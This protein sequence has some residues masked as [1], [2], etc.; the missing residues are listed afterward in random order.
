MKNLYITMFT[1]LIAGLINAQVSFSHDGNSVTV[2]YTPSEGNLP[3]NGSGEY[4]PADG[5]TPNI[6]AWCGE[7]DNSAG[8][9]AGLFGDWPGTQMTDNGNGSFSA[10]V[11]FSNF[12]AAGTTI[13]QMNFIFNGSTGQ[14]TDLGATN[15]GF[16]AFTV[17]NLGV[18]NLNSTQPIVQ[19]VGNQLMINK[20]G[21]YD[22]LVY[23]A[24]GQFVKKLQFSSAGL[25]PLNLN[26]KGIYFVRVKDDNGKVYSLKSIQK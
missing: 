22:V 10:T 21:N 15:Y 6:Y 1:L 19:M 4:S 9:F 18:A 14:T 25:Q 2:T 20:K 3:D 17:E 7:A 23:N 5:E 13:N 12:Y 16:T 24:A 8:T 26:N 11:D